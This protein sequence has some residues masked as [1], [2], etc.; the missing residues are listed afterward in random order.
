MFGFSQISLITQIIK[1]DGI[2]L[3]E[4]SQGVM[5]YVGC[6]MCYVPC[7]LDLTTLTL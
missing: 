7:D 1:N 4:H 6:S 3:L 5:C 2:F